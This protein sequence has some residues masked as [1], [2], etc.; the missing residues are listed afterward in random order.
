MFFF[1]WKRTF[2][3]PKWL[4]NDCEVI[5][6]WPKVTH[7]YP[8]WPQSNL[9]VIRGRVRGGVVE[10]LVFHF[11]RIKRRRNVCLP[12]MGS[13]GADND[14]IK[15]ATIRIIHA[16]RRLYAQSGPKVTSKWPKVTL[17][18]QNWSQSNPK[19]T[20][21]STNGYTKSLKSVGEISVFWKRTF[22]YP[23]WLHN[24]CE[25]TIKWPKVP[26]RY[27]RKGFALLPHPPRRSIS[28]CSAL[29]E[30]SSPV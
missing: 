23:K 13:L 6:K 5:I 4:H 11:D 2:I 25:V 17:I 8:N 18:Y 10:L 20:Q 22:I 1:F 12:F 28:V 24:D 27:P 26:H 3:Y 15:P 16:I 29:L 9:K 14:T 21:S 7:R 30:Y 19:S